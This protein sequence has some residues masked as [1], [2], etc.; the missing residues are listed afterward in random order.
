M[1]SISPQII[2][3][4]IPLEFSKNIIDLNELPKQNIHK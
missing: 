4:Y 1:Q 2:K 3:H